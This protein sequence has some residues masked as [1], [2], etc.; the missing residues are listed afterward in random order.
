MVEC[1]MCNAAVRGIVVPPRSRATS[2]A[3]GSRRNLGYPA[4]DHRPCADLVRIG[5]VRTVADDARVWEVGPRHSSCEAGEQRGTPCGAIR[6]GGNCGGASGAKGGGQ[7]ECGPAKH[8]PDAEP[9][10]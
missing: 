5:K 2:R 4:S 7:G 10:S 8:V 1:N 9:G 6:G 3:N